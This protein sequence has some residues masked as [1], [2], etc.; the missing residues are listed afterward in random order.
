MNG[1]SGTGLKRTQHPA[2]ETHWYAEEKSF[3]SLLTKFARSHPTPVAPNEPNDR[4]ADRSYGCRVGSGFAEGRGQRGFSVP[5]LTDRS[6]SR[7]PTEATVMGIPPRLP[8]GAV[9]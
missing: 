6:Q 2:W 7:E 4:R 1:F 3:L 8:E 9:A 5:A